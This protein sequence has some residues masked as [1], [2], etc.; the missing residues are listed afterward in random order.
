[1]GITITVDDYGSPAKKTVDPVMDDDV[2]ASA[3]TAPAAMVNQIMLGTIAP[4]A[5]RTKQKPNVGNA[6]GLYSPDAAL[7]L[8]K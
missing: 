1:V 8:A 4:R 5:D 3:P 6:Q 7:F 2:L